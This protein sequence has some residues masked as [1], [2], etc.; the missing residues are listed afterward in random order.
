MQLGV[1]QLLLEVLLCRI[2]HHRELYDILAV[3]QLERRLIGIR[4]CACKG[5]QYW[6]TLVVLH[7]RVVHRLALELE[8]PSKLVPVFCNTLQIEHLAEA[9][10]HLIRNKGILACTGIE[11]IQTGHDRVLV[12]GAH[13]L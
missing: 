10:W 5:Y 8:V 7:S 1:L 12:C 9:L 4:L 2:H 3:L 6:P 13:F 11:R